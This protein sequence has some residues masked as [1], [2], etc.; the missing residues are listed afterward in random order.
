MREMYNILIKISKNENLSETDKTTCNLLL[1]QYYYAYGSRSFKN[2]VNDF[3]TG[4]T[5]KY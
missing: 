1:D 2:E 4:I 3:I 5:L